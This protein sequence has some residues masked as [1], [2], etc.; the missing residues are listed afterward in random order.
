MRIDKYT[1]SEKGRKDFALKSRRHLSRVSVFFEIKATN[2]IAIAAKQGPD[3][4]DQKFMKETKKEV[5]SLLD[6]KFRKRLRFLLARVSHD[7]NHGRNRGTR[8]IE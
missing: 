6:R 2:W 3:I 7:E 8:N 1:F 4:V 5:G